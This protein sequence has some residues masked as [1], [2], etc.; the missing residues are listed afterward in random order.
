MHQTKKGNEWHFGMKLYIGTDSKTGLIH[1][2]SVTAANVHDSHEV[3]NLL[4]GEETRFY[5]YSAYRNCPLTDADRETNRRK[6]SVRP[7]VEHPFL[8]IK[9]LWGFAKVR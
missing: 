4:H 2:A 3:P 8:T 5:G 9:R 6:S 7:K 1:S